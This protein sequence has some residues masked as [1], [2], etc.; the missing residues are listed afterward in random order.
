MGIL[1][2]SVT[3]PPPC[4]HP[5]TATQNST[6]Q[7]P[8]DGQTPNHAGQRW[9]ALCAMSK[10]KLKYSDSI[11]DEILNSADISLKVQPR[12]RHASAGE[13]PFPK[14]GR[15]EMRLAA[16]IRGEG[17]Q[18]RAS[19]DTQHHKQQPSLKAVTYRQQKPGRSS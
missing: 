15:E 11:K 1:P 2:S 7:L 18:P 13:M 19:L 9:R 17:G 12:L 14:S 5:G 3:P 6:H 10:F 4:L 8:V 16:G